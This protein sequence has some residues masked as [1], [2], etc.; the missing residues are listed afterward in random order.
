MTIVEMLEQSGV[1]TL[2]GMGVVFGF[3]VIL[4]VAVTLM[5][6]LIHAIGADKDLNQPAKTGSGAGPA[7]AAASATAVTA[8]ITAAVTEY[9]K[10]NP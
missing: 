8:A 9:R 10:T 7:K 6:K 5:G 1:L 3:L 2:L 4:I